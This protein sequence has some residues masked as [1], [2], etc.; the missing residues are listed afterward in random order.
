MENECSICLK[1]INSEKL[2]ETNCN[3]K[4]HRKCLIKMEIN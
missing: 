3:H 4:F 1:I 2:L